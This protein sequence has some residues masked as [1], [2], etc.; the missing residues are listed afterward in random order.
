M[1]DE[2]N[3]EI[4]Q[5][6]KRRSDFIETKKYNSAKTVPRKDETPLELGEKQNSMPPFFEDDDFFNDNDADYLLELIG[7]SSTSDPLDDDFKKETQSVEQPEEP[8]E[9]EEGEPL[10]DAKPETSSPNSKTEM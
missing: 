7:L 8:A 3:N 6:R 1:L 9:K 5:L 4:E 10:N 2:I